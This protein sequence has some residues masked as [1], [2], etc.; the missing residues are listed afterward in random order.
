V[1]ARM[2]SPG[3]EPARVRGAGTT[4]LLR[5]PDARSLVVRMTRDDQARLIGAGWSA[6]ESDDTSPF[7]WMTATEARLVLPATGLTA[8]RLR[9]EGLL[10][11]GDGP[12][13]GAVVVNHVRLPAQRTQVGWHAYEWEVP[14]ALSAALAGAPAELTIVVDRLDKSSGGAPRGLAIASLRLAD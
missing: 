14:D 1:S 5:G 12:G 13:E 3:T 11:D 7:R 10:A 2:T 8:G 6:V 4:G 9:L